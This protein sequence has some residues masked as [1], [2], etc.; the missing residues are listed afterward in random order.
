[1]AKFHPFPSAEFDK[2]VL[3]NAWDVPPVEPV[4]CPAIGTKRWQTPTKIGV[5][6][7]IDP[8]RPG[9][10][11]C[12]WCR[13]LASMTEGVRTSVIPQSGVNGAH[14]ETCEAALHPQTAQA[15]RKSPC[16]LASPYMC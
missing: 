2:T 12:C 3:G 8:L 10:V 15:L 16:L 11:E 7:R 6:M 1:M 9:Q 13:M 5:A 14:G 4:L